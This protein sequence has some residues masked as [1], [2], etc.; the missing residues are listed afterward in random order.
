MKFC[1]AWGGSASSWITLR[2]EFRHSIRVEDPE[3][4]RYQKKECRSE[5]RLEEKGAGNR[6]I[7]PEQSNCWI[8]SL[9][10]PD[11][12][13]RSSPHICKPSSK[14]SLPSTTS[15]SHPIDSE[16]ALMSRSRDI[17]MNIRWNAE[18]IRSQ[19]SQATINSLRRRIWKNDC[20]KAL[21]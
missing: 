6:M 10:V 8:A 16:T 9:S 3:T 5:T 19:L 12:A 21:T 18:I 20:M 2:R 4:G 17:A 1:C 15:G 11:E 14:Q 7:C 13:S